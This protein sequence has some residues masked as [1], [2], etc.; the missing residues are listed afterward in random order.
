MKMLQNE[1]R[2]WY[3]YSRGKL[4]LSN[5][6]MYVGRSYVA[7]VNQI[8]MY[9]IPLLI[10]LTLTSVS[11]IDS[12]S[13]QSGLDSV[14]IGSQTWMTSSLNVST[15]RNGDAIQQA[16]SFEDWVRACENGNPAWCYVNGNASEGVKFGKLYNYAAVMDSRGL[17]PSGWRIPS[18]E[19]FEA[20]VT[21]LGGAKSALASLKSKTDWPC[22]DLPQ[23]GV[24]RNCYDWNAEYRRKVPCHVCQDTRRVSTG[25][26]RRCGSGT[27]ASGFDAKPTGYRSVYVR[28]STGPV[29][30]LDNGERFPASYFWSTSGDQLL[31]NGSSE[32]NSLLL[33]NAYRNFG[34]LDDVKYK[35]YGVRC[36]RS[37]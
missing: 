8:K 29:K 1:I 25:T 10:L 30:F 20:L 12:G 21:Y 28:R 4:D 5:C 14:R 3:D 9:R 24:C 33:P 32:Y 16:Q 17:A 23:T 35:G 27:N 31:L 26:E 36:I 7:V 22:W 18:E 13:F 6:G 2:L 34:S 11:W 15:F 37:N 19:D